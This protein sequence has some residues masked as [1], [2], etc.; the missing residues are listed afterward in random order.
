MRDCLRRTHPGLDAILGSLGI[1]R[2]TRGCEAFENARVEG[3]SGSLYDE[4]PNGGVPGSPDQ[5]TEL[6]D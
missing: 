4:T 3:Q 6:S 5:G 1:K 2:N